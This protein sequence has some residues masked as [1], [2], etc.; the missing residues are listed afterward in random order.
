MR[1]LAL[2]FT[3]R[4]RCIG[5]GTCENVCPVDGPSGIRVQRLLSKDTREGSEE[6]HRFRFRFGRGGR[7]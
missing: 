7:G 6:G 5:C 1:R 3:I 4:D 2:P